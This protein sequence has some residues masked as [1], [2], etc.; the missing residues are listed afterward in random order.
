MVLAF[1]II[2]FLLTA[3]VNQEVTVGVDGDYPTLTDFIAELDTLGM[4]GNTTVS[5]ISDIVEPGTV[6]IT[7]WFELFG[8]NYYLT[9]KPAN[10]SWTIEADVDTGA[11]IELNWV[12]RVIIDGEYNIGERN[13][14]IKN[15]ATSGTN[16]AIFVSSVSPGQECHFITIKNT[17][18]IGSNTPQSNTETAGIL[19]SNTPF[20]LNMSGFHDNVLIQNNHIKRASQGIV[21]VGVPVS[22]MTTDV[23]Q[24]IG[25]EMALITNLNTLDIKESE[26]LQLHK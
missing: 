11:V 10:G 15:T 12:S 9:I 22:G 19:L 26:F 21:I 23:I 25:N 18:L 14:T 13:L 17:V 16:A 6:L 1:L 24:I 7:Q 3:Q 2:P 4:G 8:E 20:N 5:I